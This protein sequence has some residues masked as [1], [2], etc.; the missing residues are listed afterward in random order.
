[1]D[2]K[3]KARQWLTDHA[4]PLWLEN[5]IHADGSFVENLSREAKPLPG[6]Q[7]CMVQARQI[8]SFCEAV[9]MGLWTKDK[10]APIVTRATESFIQRYSMPSGAFTH[11]VEED[12]EQSPLVDLY[13]QSFA[14]FGLANAFELTGDVKFKE[15][16]L[17]HID[18]LYKERRLLGGSGFSEYVGGEVAFEANPHMHLFEA[19]LAWMRVDADEFQWRNLADEISGLCVG[20]FVD[21]ETGAL[22]E[23]FDVNWKPLRQNNLFVFEPGHHY[24]WAWLLLQYE[25]LTS[26]SA[27]AIPLLLFEVAEKYG[28]DAKTGLAVDEVWSDGRV[29]K[30][31]SRFWPQTER[32]KASVCLAEEAETEELKQG[33]LRVSDQA[34]AGLFKF[35]DP[36][37]PGLWEDML[38]ENGK[39]TDLYVKASSL[40]HII[41]AWSEYIRKR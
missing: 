13:A 9:R 38:L 40:Y 24:E 39:F 23:H 35:L 30:G 22:C 26:A 1:M 21:R 6:S 37:K 2:L 29:K 27:G 15:R 41:C 8:Y 32:I 31:S 28:V 7:R 3:L 5:G 33:F 25:K 34:A 18:Y 14:L 12:G 10:I 36:V 16:A 20:R 4:L 19:S 17:Q 11:L